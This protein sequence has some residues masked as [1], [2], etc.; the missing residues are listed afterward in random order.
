LRRTEDKAA[1]GTL[2]LV[3]RGEVAPED[4][5]FEEPADE[6]EYRLRTCLRCGADPRGE[7]HRDGC[8]MEDECQTT[9][10]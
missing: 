2:Y 8:P 4:M 6:L 10:S 9:N 1:A 7:H 3:E 5:M